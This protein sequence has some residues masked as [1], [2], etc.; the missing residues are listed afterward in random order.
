LCLCLFFLDPFFSSILEHVFSLIYVHVF[1]FSADAAA[2]S[3]LHIFAYLASRQ[4]QRPLMAMHLHPFLPQV[5]QTSS[6]PASTTQPTG[7]DTVVVVTIAG[8]AAA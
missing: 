4:S 2:I 7:A 1:P 6:L 3:F 8:V 5:G